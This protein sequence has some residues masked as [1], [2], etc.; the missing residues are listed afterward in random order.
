MSKFFDTNASAK[1]VDEALDNWDFAAVEDGAKQKQA[2]AGLRGKPFEVAEG[3]A[4]VWDWLAEY[5][6]ATA[7]DM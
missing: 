2:L 6:S 4:D 5:A 7:A 1:A 3:F